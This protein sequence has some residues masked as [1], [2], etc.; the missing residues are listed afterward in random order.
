MGVIA[1]G[2][3]ASCSDNPTSSDQ[4]TVTMQAELAQSGVSKTVAKD[5]G[6][7]LLSGSQADSLKV[8]RVRILISELKLHRSNEDT[9]SGDKKV[10]IGPMLVTVDSTGTRTFTSGAVPAGSYEKLKF[11]FH[12]FSSSEVPQYLNDT[13]FADFVTDK[14]YS[15]IIDGTV[16]NGGTAFPFTYRSDATA[17]LELKF[18]PAITLAPG[19]TAIVVLKIDPIELF[20][21]NGKVLDPRDGSNESE[22][23]NAIKDAIKALKR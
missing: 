14:R 13:I 16:Y 12:R 3:I 18:D 1:L 20:K 9:V 5:P 19:S 6:T 4:A 23:D 8:S 21:H 11:E 10:K 15:F 22:I 17:N 7:V 2:A